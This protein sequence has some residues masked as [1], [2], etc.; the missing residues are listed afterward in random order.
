MKYNSGIK[1]NINKHQNRFVA[2]EWVSFELAFLC[3]EISLNVRDG[4]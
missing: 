1:C 4:H 3:F 2:T